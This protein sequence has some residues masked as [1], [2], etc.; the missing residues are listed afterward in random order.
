MQGTK[1]L[2]QNNITSIMRWA[3]WGVV[4]KKIQMVK[5]FC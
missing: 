4:T 3:A 5:L 1:L 2:L